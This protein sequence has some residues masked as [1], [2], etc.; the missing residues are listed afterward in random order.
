M[1]KGRWEV[2]GSD[3]VAGWVFD[4]S[5]QDATLSVCVIINDKRLDPV[6]ANIPQ[7]NIEAESGSEGHA[8]YVNIAAILRPGFNTIS[9]EVIG[10]DFR[11]ECPSR[12][13]FH[14]PQDGAFGKKL[15]ADPRIFLYDSQFKREIENNIPLRSARGTEFLTRMVAETKVVFILFTNRSGS[16]L[17][18]E[19]LKSLGLGGGVTHEPFLADVI[20]NQ[21]A[22]HGYTSVEHYLASTINTYRNNGTVFFKIGWDA[23]FF[24]TYAGVIGDW[25]QNSRFIWARRRDKIMQAISYIKALRTGIFF[26]NNTDA[27]RSP[28]SFKSV[29]QGDATLWAI[30]E[31]HRHFHEAD[32][33]LGYFLELMDVSALEVWYEDINGDLPG[34]YNRV[35]AYVE[36]E[37]GVNTATSE[38]FNPKL[39][40]HESIDSEQIKQLYLKLVKLPPTTG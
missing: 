2:I 23:L 32:T 13:L 29:W 19:M 7:P 1:Y 8:F 27:P 40:K 10:S 31:M 9:V 5:H 35:R 34:T 20:R 38:T 6:P 37:I 3:R 18:T 22:K 16:N 12:N 33:R 17:V 25:L 14:T 15:R 11:F 24:L 28:S 26:E 30:A 21:V 4:V 36:D 39:R